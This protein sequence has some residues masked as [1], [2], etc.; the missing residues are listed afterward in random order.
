MQ[1][2]LFLKL[3]ELGVSDEIWIFKWFLTYFLY[4]FPK[5]VVETV[6]DITFTRGGIGQI[7]FAYAITEQ[8]R[9]HLMQCSDD[10]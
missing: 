4:S 10:S 6:W 8:I 1:P 2:K 9:H 3:A 7:Y 5:E